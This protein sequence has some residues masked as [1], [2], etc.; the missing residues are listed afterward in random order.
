MLSGSLRAVAAPTGAA[1]GFALQRI[2]RL[3]PNAIGLSQAAV[4]S[5]AAVSSASP[6]LHSETLREPE[7]RQAHG[8]KWT[9][10]YR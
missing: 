3:L 4:K 2:V 8:V 10:P 1:D 7:Q 9:D 5:T 6:S